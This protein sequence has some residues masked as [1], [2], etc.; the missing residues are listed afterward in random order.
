MHP[1]IGTYARKLRLLPLTLTL[2]LLLL[3]LLAAPPGLHAQE[4]EVQRLDG[5]SL[6]LENFEDQQPGMLPEGWYDRDGNRQLREHTASEQESYKYA[7]ME[8]NGNRFLRYE[9]TRARHINY[10][11][12]NKESVNIHDTPVLSWRVRAHELPE[13]ANEDSNGLND[14]VA[15][16]YVVF[17]FG[18]VMFQKVPKSIRYSW[19]TTRETG[20]QFSKLFGNQKIIVVESGRARTG[21][22][23][24]FE[25]NIYEDYRELF[26]EA[27]PEQPLAILVLS[28]GD[29]TGSHVMADYDDFVLKP[30]DR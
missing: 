2:S 8:E 24:T 15:S 27:P 22:W 5:G 18:H 29:S 19:S 3:S 10:P 17:D 6:L 7:V 13:N 26:G 20:S 11:L 25:R 1:L 14:S 23:V 30:A 28:D 16:V 9:G 21:E 4:G 12:L